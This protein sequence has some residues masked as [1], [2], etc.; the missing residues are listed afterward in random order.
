MNHILIRALY[1]LN[2]IVAGMIAYSS[3]KSPDKAAISVFSNAY[4]STE[5][6]RLVGCLW[7]GI[8]VLSIFGLF[9]PIKFAPVMVLQ[10]IYKGSWL[11]FVALPA[12]KASQPY[13]KGMAGFFVVWVIV[14]PFIIPWK[15]LFS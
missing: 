12:I 9:F 10:L 8:T 13:P 15:V 4:A 5:V 3:I 6:M 14:L 11:I 2:I 7:L 1:V